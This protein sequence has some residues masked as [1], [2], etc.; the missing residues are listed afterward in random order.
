MMGALFALFI[1]FIDISFILVLFWGNVRAKD[2]MFQA[3]DDGGEIPGVGGITP[4]LDHNPTL[5]ISLP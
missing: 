2:A 3:Y 4:R 1:Y 5:S